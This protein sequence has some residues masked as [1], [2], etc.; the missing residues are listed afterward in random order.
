MTC[1]EKI[2]VI[3]ESKGLFPEVKPHVIEQGINLVTILEK[4]A[5]DA[6]KD[7]EV[8]ALAMK[9]ASLLAAEAAKAQTAALV[10]LKPAGIKLTCTKFDGGKDRHQYKQWFTQ[11]TAMIEASGVEDNRVKSVTYPFSLWWSCFKVSI[12]I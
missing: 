8:H 12:R 6:K 5:A 2:Y 11:F 9:N 3:I 1:R 7:R 10:K 4:L